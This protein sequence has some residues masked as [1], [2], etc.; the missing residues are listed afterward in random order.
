M[1]TALAQAR[2]L[3]ASPAFDRAPKSLRR[4]VLLITA[5]AEGRTIPQRRTRRTG[6][7]HV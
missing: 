1:P 3:L 4:L 7:Q 5:S 2:A 6:A